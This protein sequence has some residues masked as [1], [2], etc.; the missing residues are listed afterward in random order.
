MITL[1][2][3]EKLPRRLCK[4]LIK[5]VQLYADFLTLVC[6]HT[7]SST[8]SAAGSAVSSGTSVAGMSTGSMPLLLNG[9]IVGSACGSLPAS[10]LMTA[11]SMEPDPFVGSSFAEPSLDLNNGRL[12]LTQARL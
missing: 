5:T 12:R 4:K 1:V 7:V 3:N 6:C 2:I 9:A 8:S 10:D 11:T